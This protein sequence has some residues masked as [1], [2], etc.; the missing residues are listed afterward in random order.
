VRKLKMILI[1]TIVLFLSGCN[2]TAPNEKMGKMKIVSICRGQKAFFKLN[3]RYGTFDELVSANLADSDITRGWGYKT[4][5][6]ITET[7]YFASVTPNDF[8]KAGM[9]YLDE[10]GIIKKHT[11]DVNVNSDDTICKIEEGCF[12]G[13]E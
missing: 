13:D 12:C 5:I 3:R 10:K 2:N 8:T 9:F 6:K 4:E 7:G 11:G 1:L